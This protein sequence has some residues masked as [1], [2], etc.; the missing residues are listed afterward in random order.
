MTLEVFQSLNWKITVILNLFQDLSGLM[1]GYQIG[2]MLKY[3]HSTLPCNPRSARKQEELQVQ[4]DGIIPYERGL[5]RFKI[6][7]YL[8]FLCNHN[9]LCLLQ[10][11]SDIYCIINLMLSDKNI[12]IGVTGGIAAYKVCEL[13]RMF[14]KNSANVKVVVTPNALEFVTELTLE[15]LSQEKVYTGQFNTTERKPE[16]IS[17]CD[18]AD[19]FVI[20]PASANTIGKL[21]NGICDNLL[22]SLACA[23]KKPILIAPAMNTGM[24]ENSF[25]QENLA[26]LQREN[27]K[28]IEPE[29]GFLACGTDGKGRLAAIDK[30]FEESKEILLSSTPSPA[31]VSSA[32]SAG[33]PG[34]GIAFCNGSAVQTESGKK[35][36]LKGKKVLITAGGTRENIDPVRFIGNYS[37]G[38][39]GIA[40]AD[41]AYSFGAEV[42]L[43]YACETV[44]KKPYK[45]INAGSAYEMRKAVLENTADIV[46]MAA[47]VADFR[48][49][50]V[51]DSKIKKENCN[52]FTSPPVAAS[53][54]S[55]DNAGSPGFCNEST[56]QAELTI[57]LVQN[58]DI[59]A[60]ICAMKKPGQ[61]IAGF[62]A[63]SED[64]IE[65]AK[66]KIR[67][68][69]CDFIIAND[70]SRKDI[71][72]SSEYNEVVILDKNLNTKKLERDKK[73]NIAEKILEYCLNRAP[74]AEA[75][76]PCVVR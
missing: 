32:S 6:L 1:F 33:S 52:H 20:A 46:I 63:E 68:K 17:L 37:S 34:S 27:Y 11:K 26:R 4:H 48:P 36:F 70:I 40:L 61:I 69:G 59:L 67:E 22:T 5:V 42:T 35:Q 10:Q 14:K 71:A 15:T 44:A 28:I 39:M 13:V 7:K 49:V 53:S 21:A 31:L 58:P 12:L 54:K 51:S 19:L 60:E 64:L 38:R 3:S 66:K 74:A 43:I 23:F 24:W 55:P 72:F 45:M 65:N 16:H 18:W 62:C 57:K 76:R 9:P 50:E 29:D 47:A 56:I 30:I 75:G 25:V 73:E 41:K 8:Q 2:K